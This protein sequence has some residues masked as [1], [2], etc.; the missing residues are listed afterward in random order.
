MSMTNVNRN[1]VPVESSTTLMVHILIGG[2]E[3]LP[4]VIWNE[5]VAKWV[6]MGWTYVE[7][8]NVQ[9]LN[10]T[11]FLATYAVGIMADEIGA[12]IEK[13]NNWLG[14]PVVITCDEVTVA[15]PHHVLECAQCITGVKSVVFNNRMD[16]LSSDS[17][18]SVRN[19]Y[20][21]N[22]ASPAALEASGPT[23]LNKILGIPHFLGTEREKDT[24]QFKQWYHAISDAWKNFNEQLVRAAI[25]KSCVGDVADAMCC[26]L[27]GATLDHILEK[28]K[29]L[30]G[31]VESSDTLMLEFYRITQE[32]REKV[33]TFVLHLE[34]AL[35][36]IKQQHLYAMTEEEGHRHLI[37]C[38]IP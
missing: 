27:L 37:N 13:F 21:S 30:Y 36:V 14:K 35:E 17:L 5:E 18:Q 4:Q 22:A 1:A 7:T 10:E 29:W 11:T 32:K 24:V 6:F 15:Q 2:K 38:P 34:R 25:T 26:L 3:I 33:Q 28:F 31:S 8:K 12:A 23:I 19:G 9:S 20:H 16:D